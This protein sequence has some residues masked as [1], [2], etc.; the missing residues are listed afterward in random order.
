MKGCVPV[1][2]E[3]N[4]S[5][6]CT[7]L[8]TRIIYEYAQQSGQLSDEVGAHAAA[9][10]HCTRL[11]ETLSEMSAE[12]LALLMFVEALRPDAA[13]TRPEVPAKS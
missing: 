7:E 9:C 10:Q 4:R 5:P 3:T 2:S 13:W 8:Q 11:V 1:S 6:V 12:A